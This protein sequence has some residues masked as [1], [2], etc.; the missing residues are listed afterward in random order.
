[1]TKTVDIVV[2]GVDAAAVRIILASARKGLS[3]LVVIR[4][5]RTS[6]ERRLRRTLRASGEDV[7][8]RVSIMTGAEIACADGVAGVEAIVIRRIKTG[9]L[10][11]VNASA[12][13]RIA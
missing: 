10:I 3:V 2:P 11:G 5:T 13:E 7:R 6:L 8:Q 9:R 1:M 12:I 4:S